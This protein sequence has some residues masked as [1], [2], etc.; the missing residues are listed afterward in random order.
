MQLEIE[1]T[2]LKGEEDGKSKERLEN[3]RTEL[4]ELKA[5]KD[6]LYTKWND[7]KAALEETKKNRELLEKAKLDLEQAQNETRYEDA[8]RL[9]YE[10]IPNLEKK[11]KEES[12]K[13]KEDALLSEV[14]SEEDVAKIVSK[15]SGVEVSRLAESERE[16]LLK[17]K[18]VLEQ[19]VIGQ[20]NALTLVSDA[21]LRSKAGIQDENRP[22]GSF[23]FL[24][25]TG[26][27]KTEVAKA[28]AEQLFDSDTHIIRIDMSEDMEK[29]SVARLIGAPP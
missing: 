10:T 23:M 3:I 26:V 4:K 6:V 16:K 2:A 28:L 7:E 25:P 5:Q 22:I 29:H 15:W 13:E 17:L 11:I 1:E 8:A 21:I 12:E 20:D 14:V 9:R 24:G 19:R 18:E 27:G